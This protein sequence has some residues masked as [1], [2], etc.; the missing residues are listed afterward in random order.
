MVDLYAFRFA[1]QDDCHGRSRV[2]AMA[3]LRE[4]QKVLTRRVLLSSA[5]A[6]FREKGYAAATI[7]DIAK[8]AGTTRV[9][10][11]A[12]FPSKTEV[13]KALIAEQLN[14]ILQRIGSPE[15]GSTAP[16][17]VE[18]AAAG[19]REQ[20][21]AWMRET[22]AKWPDVVPLIQL[23][24]EAGYVDAD[25]RGLIDRWLEEA[26][27]DLVAGLEQADRF[28]PETRKFRAV[29]AMSQFDYV[30]RHWA[31][32]DWG[33]SEEKMLATLTDSWFALLG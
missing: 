31:V 12:Y 29:L 13:M 2:L 18:V 7:D 32:S 6:V 16:D 28:D 33:I 19:S 23:G 25:L 8:A 3:T 21:G 5:L 14:E 9:T 22:V 1:W 24:R 26:E 15:H 4:Q 20:I 27:A 11:Y 10:F 17:L 30:A